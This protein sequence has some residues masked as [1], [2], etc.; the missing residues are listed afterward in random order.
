MCLKIVSKLVWRLKGMHWSINHLLCILA[1]MHIKNV[2]E[3][4]KNELRWRN[5][6]NLPVNRIHV[7]A[8]KVDSCNGSIVRTYKSIAC[9]HMATWLGWLRRCRRGGGGR[10]NRAYVTWSSRCWITSVHVLNLYSVRG[11]QDRASVVLAL[12]RNGAVG[13][14]SDLRWRAPRDPSSNGRPTIF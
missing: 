10:R 3:V 13:C 14:C 7:V 11:R 6:Q 12:T 8:W 1:L 2:L 5:D 9:N 4:T